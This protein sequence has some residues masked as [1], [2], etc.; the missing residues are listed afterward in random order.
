MIQTIPAIPLLKTN[1]NVIQ[2]VSSVSDNLFD[3]AVS[4]VMAEDAD[5]GCART[6]G[7]ETRFR[8]VMGS[9]EE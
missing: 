3:E 1:A 7:D 5:E 9:D 8:H 2:W 4:A 6:I